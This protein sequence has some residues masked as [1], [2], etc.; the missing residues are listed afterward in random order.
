MYIYAYKIYKKNFVCFLKYT[1]AYIYIYIYIYI[2]P[3]GF[4]FYECVSV[5]PEAIRSFMIDGKHIHLH[6][7]TSKFSSVIHTYIYICVCVCVCVAVCLCNCT[8]KRSI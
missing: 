5:C 7:H 2:I 3:S 4:V 1:I 8:I 6:A